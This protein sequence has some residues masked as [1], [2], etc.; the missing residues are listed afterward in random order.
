MKT[1]TFPLFRLAVLWLSALF[2]FSDSLVPSAHAQW[3]HFSLEDAVL[4]LHQHLRPEEPEQISWEPETD[5]IYRVMGEAP[6]LYWVQRSFP[7]FDYDTLFSLHALRGQAQGLDSIRTMP[8]FQWIA[9]GKAWFRQGQGIYTG[10]RDTA[11]KWNWTRE[12]ILP[13]KAANL[14]FDGHN[15][16]AYTLDN[17][18][19]LQKAGQDP[20]QV[21]R[22]EN[23]QI[24]SGIAVHREEFGIKK[25]IF[26]S[27]SGRYMAYYR[28]D[29]SMVDDYPIIDWSGRIAQSRNIK[30]PMAGQKSHEVQVILLDTETRNSWPLNT[31]GPR[32][33]YLVSLT[34]S[35]DEKD[36][37]LG[38]LNRDQ[39]HLRLH[40][41]DRSSGNS[42]QVLFEEKQAAYV[43]PQHP[44]YFINGNSGEFIWRS[45]RDGY[46]HLYHYQRDGKL[47]RQLTQ[48]PWVVDELVGFS[49]ASQELIFLAAHPSPLERH[50][51]RLDWKSGE[52]RE[53]DRQPGMH[54]GWLS[55]T[56]HYLLDRLSNGETPSRYMIHGLTD[57]SI[58]AH[59]EAADPLKEYQRA[60]VE[61][62]DWETEDGTRLYGKLVMPGDLD[63][64]RRYPLVVYVYNGPHVQLVKNSYPA[65]GNLWYEYL[66]Q[67]GYIVFFMDGRGSARRGL[68]FEQKIFRHLGNWE[69][70]D[71]VQGL[72][73]IRALPFVDTQR[74][75]VY[76]WS[77]GGFMTTSL[78]VHHP[79]L[80]RVGVAG[81]AVLD[82][83]AYEVMYTERYMDRPQDNPEG[84]AA[85]R[86]MDKVEQIQDPLLL[87]HGTE[88]DVVLWQHSLK[89]LQEAVEK[90]VSLDYFVYP[91]HGHNVRGK[92]RV[93]LMRKITD[94]LDQHLK[95]GSSD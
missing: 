40:R 83:A 94:Y 67:K 4:G 32:D 39:N 56:G 80:F 41:F 3:R 68:D 53:V 60:R 70:K 63:S 15:Q 93:H 6:H 42:A 18:L 5:N 19:W 81:G 59:F 38:L 91:G 16:W 62:L 54:S 8:R 55:G 65:S 46:S 28:M 34:W 1:P 37:Y 21:T 9:Q 12:F 35:P 22:E 10:Q 69:M 24:H 88:D 45:Q 89:F 17:Q 31:E 43:E 20:W 75:G 50:L 58:E 74:I 85:S 36:L 95:P 77:Y 82:W 84:Y 76:G 51:F 71:Q 27:P 72:Q 11:G 30:Y 90:G 47:I 44:L 52:I 7:A 33:Q 23:P 13:E 66:C 2:T 78:L 29:E 64:L 49:Q 92:D 87:I 26:F 86:L 48:G 61:T 14:E 73:K 25:G 57:H 79:D